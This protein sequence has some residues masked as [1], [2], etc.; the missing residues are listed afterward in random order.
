[1]TVQQPLLTLQIEICI[2]GL[3]VSSVT[4]TCYNRGYIS[5]QDP[6]CFKSG[7][8]TTMAD[9]PVKK[10]TTLIH[11]R[12]NKTALNSTP[13]FKFIDFVK[14]SVPRNT[15]TSIL[16]M[17]RQAGHTLDGISVLAYSKLAVII[18][19]H[20]LNIFYWVFTLTIRKV[21]RNPLLNIFKAD[22]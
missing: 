15:V 5:L 22:F 16:S 1:M 11:R 14:L 7:N 13:A 4:E 18:C 8:T 3:I 2:K 21:W 12:F 17:K 6:L 20:R 10:P 19:E 9:Q